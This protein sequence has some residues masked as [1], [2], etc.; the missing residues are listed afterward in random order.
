M[1]T[2]A[3]S[4][5]W[6]I[7]DSPYPSE[8]LQ[9][10]ME[11]GK[12]NPSYLIDQYSGRR[13]ALINA[14]FLQTKKLEFKFFPSALLDSNLARQVYAVANGGTV[15][16]GF[17]DLL[18]H[19]TIHGWDF[20]LYFYYLEHYCKA[21]SISDFV[22]NAEVRTEALL[23]LHSMDNRKYLESGEIEPN[24]EAVSHYL[25]STNSSSLAEVAHKRVAE[26]T[27]NHSKVDTETTIETIEIAIAKMVLIRRFEHPKGSP[28]QQY[29][30]FK[31]FLE[32]DLGAMLAREAHL[33]L[34]YFYDKAGRLLGTQASTPFKRAASNISS[35]AWDMYF[36]RF[37]ELLFSGSPTE[38]SLA[39]IAT[40][41]KQ[42]AALARLFSVESIIGSRSN[43]ILPVIGYQSSGLP[44]E[45]MAVV[46]PARPSDIQRKSVSVGLK[47]A[48]FNELQRLLPP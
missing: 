23:K 1:K 48:L 19:L 13:P 39:F 45:A 3:D 41:E 34:H 26:F 25:A 8:V 14:E 5:V 38:M 22:A 30:M 6:Q 21:A 2:E 40:Q 43:G 24:P 11:F 27:K 35:T 17:R 18:K 32:H 36:L 10:S 37:P 42:L 7:A 12:V 4:Y 47:S 9:G 33:A 46:H 29:E 20:S 28:L 16:D 31:K 44:P 15:N